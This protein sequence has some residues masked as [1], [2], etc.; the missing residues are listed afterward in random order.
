MTDLTTKQKAAIAALLE[1]KSKTAAA[2]SA[3]VGRQTLSRWLNDPAFK[4][5]LRD[6]SDET[7]RLAAVKLA[8]LAEHAINAMALVMHQP[9]EPG[10]ATRLRAADTLL[11]HV[12]RIREQ[13]DI[14]ERIAILEE[15]LP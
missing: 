1:G 5:A 13:A 15:R 9:T 4:T 12:L 3:G 7:I 14:L 6:A 2:E 8:G 11:G 10:A